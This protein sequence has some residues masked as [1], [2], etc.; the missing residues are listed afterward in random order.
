MYIHTCIHTELYGDILFDAETFRV[1]CAVH[2]STYLNKILLGSQ[3]GQLQLWNIRTNKLIY[4]FTGWGSP[5]LVLSQSPAVDVVGVGLESGDIVLHN[6]RYDETLMKFHQDWGPVI[7]I[8]FRTGGTV[9]CFVTVCLETLPFSPFFSLPP[10]PLSPFLPFSLSLASLP[11]FLFS[12][13]PPSFL[14][15]S[16]PFFSLPSLSITASFAISIL[17]TSISFSSPSP[18]SYIP[19]FPFPSSY[20]TTLPDGINTVASSSPLGHIAVWDLDNKRLGAVIRD[21][22]NGSVPGLHFLQSQPLLVTSGPDNSLKMWIFDQSDGSARLLRSRCGHSAPPTKIRFYTK[23]GL[24]LLSAGMGAIVPYT[25]EIA[26]ALVNCCR[27]SVQ[28][29]TTL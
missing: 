4:T 13:F 27:F 21:A 1:M 17:P 9:S 18:F 14:F 10:P 2:P 19:L 7:A 5:V 12:P 25:P 22:H 15:S 26:A 3:Q 20:L 28:V 23:G 6:L 16:L 8:S 29:W 11:P 24:G